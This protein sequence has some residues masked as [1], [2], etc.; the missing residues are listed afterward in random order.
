[1]SNFK[2]SALAL[3]LAVAGEPDGLNAD[4]PRPIETKLQSAINV[5]ERIVVEWCR[6]GLLRRRRPRCEPLRG[7][8]NRRRQCAGGCRGGGV[9]WP[10]S[11]LRTGAQHPTTQSHRLPWPGVGDPGA[12]QAGAASCGGAAAC[13]HPRAARC[14]GG[15]RRPCGRGPCCCGGGAGCCCC[16]CCACRCCGR[17]PRGCCC[18]RAGRCCCRG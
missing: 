12:G 8:A 11:A 18:C 7:A 15:A 10:Q 13:R 4:P 14:C 3:V 2:F 9:C 5:A 16:C 1:M 6:G 17:C